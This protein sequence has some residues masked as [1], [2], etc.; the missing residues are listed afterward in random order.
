MKSR[1]FNLIASGVIAAVFATLI[2][3]G[4]KESKQN[5]ELS[6]TRH[7][8]TIATNGFETG[9]GNYGPP[10]FQKTTKEQWSKALE[11]VNKKLGAYQ[12]HTTTSW[13][14]FKKSGTS[15]S[16]TTVSVQCQVTYSKHKATEQFTLFKG[17][18]DLE[19]K[20]T[21]HKIDSM[22]LLAE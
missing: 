20:I 12:S 10:F 2:G 22:A 15:G 8:Q 19:F 3:C 7:F 16:G 4:F 14:V 13:R 6:L 17:S 1:T 5:A 11:G 9:I 21:G 18:G